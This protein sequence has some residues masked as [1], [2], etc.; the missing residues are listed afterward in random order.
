MRHIIDIPIE[1]GYNMS[2]WKKAGELALK[3]GSKAVDELKAANERGQQYAAEFP[4]KTDDQLFN[5]IKRERK[6][7]PLKA[8]AA[9]KEL[10][11]RGYSKDTIKLM[12]S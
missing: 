5:I 9:F 10:E 3:A 4:S 1:R 2:F 6:G 12:A 7:S 8:G 11:S